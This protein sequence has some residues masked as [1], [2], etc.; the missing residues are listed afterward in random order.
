MTLGGI[1]VEAAAGG[2]LISAPSFEGEKPDIG[3]CG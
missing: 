3:G 2:V 1:V